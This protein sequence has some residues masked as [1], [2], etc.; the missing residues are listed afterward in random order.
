MKK[1]IRLTEKQLED[2]VRRVIAEQDSQ[3]DEVYWTDTAGVAYKLPGIT[4]SEKWST[5]V[6]WG[7]AGGNL[8]KGMALLR[9]FGLRYASGRGMNPNPMDVGIKWNQVRSLSDPRHRNGDKVYSMFTDG[10]A[11][12]AQ[13]GYTD[14]RYWKTPQFAKVMR[15]AGTKPADAVALFENYWDVLDKIVKLQIP[16]IS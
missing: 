15:E 2:I 11:A 9:K 6:N 14:K 4:D 3:E 13:T 5:F 8:G 10:L 1:V 16:K 12:V 7:P